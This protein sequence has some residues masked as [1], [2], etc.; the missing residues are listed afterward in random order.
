[1]YEYSSKF[2]NDIQRVTKTFQDLT[3][4][5]IVFTSAKFVIQ[6]RKVTI[7][8]NPVSKIFDGTDSAE[9]TYS[10]SGNILQGSEPV[11]TLFKESGV[12]VGKYLINA[13]VEGDIYD[14]DIITNY[15]E[16]LKR[17]VTI[18]A[19]NFEIVYGEEIPTLT[20]RVEG[21]IENSELQISL[22][23]TQ[24]K[25]AGEY[26][27]YSSILHSDNYNIT[28]IEGKLTI[29]KLKL[30]IK[31]G[32][33]IKVYGSADPIFDYEIIEGSIVDHDI[34][35]GAIIRE[36]GENVGTYKLICE[37]ENPN[38][39]I[40]FL[41]A[42]LS[43]TRKELTIVT[44]VMDKVF[45][46]TDI[47]Y[48]RTP[49]LAGVINGDDVYFDYERDKVAR[50]IQSAVGDNIAVVV[51]G[52]KLSGADC[53]NYYLTYPTNLTANITNS[54]VEAEDQKVANELFIKASNLNTLL[55]QGATLFASEYKV[56]DAEKSDFGNSKSIVGAYNLSVKVGNQ[57][58]PESGKVTV[59]I[60]PYSNG[61]NNVQVF[62][63]NSDGTK[64]LLNA[65]YEDGVIKFETDEMGTFI[66]VADNDNWLN[67]T[68]IVSAS[69]LLLT[70]VGFVIS[71]KRKKKKA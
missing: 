43:I 44:S 61:L 3:K 8:I 69:V 33:F 35:N 52:G 40:D 67:I 20:Y 31:T 34:L 66:V 60:K 71:K 56:T 68:L 48:L 10:L 32:N 15:F 7:K 65:T 53:G 46:G 6:K 1:M 13:R 54:I 49:T 25:A 16:I 47:A 58:V 21:D 51:Y 17:D 36:L 18:R 39:E 38:Y 70:I 55:K 2:L 37:L 24:S 50:F 9:L 63:L 5:N 30:V 27:I 29:K 57:D 11:V 14:V 19:D 62:R 22:Y 45:D 64:T 12:N 28:Y 42:S 26:T 23:R 59:N 41:S 4:N